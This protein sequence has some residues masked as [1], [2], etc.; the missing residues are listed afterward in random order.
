MEIIS[1]SRTSS[2][3]RHVFVQAEVFGYSNGIRKSSFF[4]P[5]LAWRFFAVILKTTQNR[6][7]YLHSDFTVAF[8]S[9]HCIGF[10]SQIMISIPYEKGL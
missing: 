10:L 2:Y 8:G 7:V 6:K 9:V 1:F 4:V 5:F 3:S